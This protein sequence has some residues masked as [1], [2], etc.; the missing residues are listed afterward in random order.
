MTSR[1]SRHAETDRD[2]GKR[3][4]HDAVALTTV[5]TASHGRPTQRMCA[6]CQDCCTAQSRRGLSLNY[7]LLRE[8]LRAQNITAGR[9][10]HCD[11]HQPVHRGLDVVWRGCLGQVGRGVRHRATLPG[12]F[13]MHRGAGHA[14]WHPELEDVGRF[15]KA[16]P[17]QLRQ[18]L[19]QRYNS[20]ELENRTH[21][22]LLKDMGGSRW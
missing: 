7:I 6:A 8:A 15:W 14:S 1:C 4:C 18:P 10:R 3:A 5:P 13:R 9:Q 21:R 22:Q 16:L 11:P 2:T 20:G 12:D 19:R 17:A